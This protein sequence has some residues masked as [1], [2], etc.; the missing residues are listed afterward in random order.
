MFLGKE[1]V[2]NLNG[3]LIICLVQCILKLVYF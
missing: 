2:D 1:S 3:K